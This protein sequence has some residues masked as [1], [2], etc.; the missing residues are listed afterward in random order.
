MECLRITKAQQD[1]GK[2]SSHMVLTW[3]ITSGIGVD[4]EYDE[5]DADDKFSQTELPTGAPPNIATPCYWTSPRG[6]DYNVDDDHLYK[7]EHYN[8]SSSSPQNITL[9]LD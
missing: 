2:K 7:K 9:L 5:D 1:L 3:K 4:N 6:D 8:I